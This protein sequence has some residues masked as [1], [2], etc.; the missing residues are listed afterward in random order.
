MR[1][2]TFD[3]LRVGR[4]PHQRVSVIEPIEFEAEIETVLPPTE[5]QPYEPPPSLPPLE[6][7]P[8]GHSFTGFHIYDPDGSGGLTGTAWCLVLLMIAGGAAG[9]GVWVT[10]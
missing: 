5:L 2:W 1:E 10:S 8:V 7:V 3:S 6:P 9:V 4:V